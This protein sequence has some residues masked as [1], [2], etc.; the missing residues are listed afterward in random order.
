MGVHYFESD[1]IQAEIVVMFDHDYE[2]HFLVMEWTRDQDGEAFTFS[3]RTLYFMGREG[4][5]IVRSWPAS[6]TYEQTLIE[7]ALIVGEWRSLL[8]SS[9]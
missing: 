2:W 8:E 7:C 1:Q 5:T 9:E 4:T 6:T 3:G